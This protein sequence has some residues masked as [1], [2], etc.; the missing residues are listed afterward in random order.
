M[1]LLA[2]AE[3]SRTTGQ[4]ERELIEMLRSPMMCANIG[5]GG[6]SSSHGSPHFLYVVFR[7]DA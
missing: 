5:A 6:E 7:S 2:V 4:L 3:S 1:F